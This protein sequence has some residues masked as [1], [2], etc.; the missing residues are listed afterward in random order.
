MSSD[1]AL[2]GFT[3]PAAHRTL[4]ALDGSYPPAP[5]DSAWA[6]NP[7]LKATARFLVDLTVRG[8][9]ALAD[10]P[11]LS[12]RPYVRHGGSSGYVA[13]GSATSFTRPRLK[14]AS[15]IKAQFTTDDGENYTDKSAE[16]ID[17]T[18]GV[19]TLNSL[20]TAGN[21]D[22]IVIGGPAPFCGLALDVTNTNSNNVALTVEY[23]NGSAWVAVSNL[24]DGTNSSGTLAAD[25][26][27]T[28]D[29][30]SGVS[31]PADWAQSTINDITAYWVRLSVAGALDSSVTLTE[32]DLLFPIRAYF[33][34]ET[35]GGDAMILIEQQTASVTGTPAYS[36]AAKVTWR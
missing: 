12:I 1:L 32:V 24:T 28:W 7:G 34:I 15:T 9:T 17:N 35:A 36:G 23:W 8:T 3:A 19:M 18:T 29:G 22:W 13:A 31:V 2:F 11:V 5:G 30:G 21:G 6:S 10:D 14:D 16:V 4:T 25:G 20:D 26:Q 33:D 27:V